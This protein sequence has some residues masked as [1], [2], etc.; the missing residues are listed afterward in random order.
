ML[1]PHTEILGLIA[2]GDWVD[3]FRYVAEPFR[4]TILPESDTRNLKAHII[5]KVMAAKDRFDVHFV[6]PGVDEYTPPDVGEW[7]DEETQLPV[8]GSSRE[9]GYF[10]RGNTGPRWMLG[11][12]MS[13]PFINAAHCEGKF[14]ISSIEGSNVY[15]STPSSSKMKQ[16]LAGRWLTFPSVD[17]CLVMFEGLLKVK[18]KKQG[19]HEEEEE[20]TAVREGQTL[21]IAAGQTFALEFA[22]GYVRAISFTNG[23]GIE[24]LIQTAGSPFAGFVL[25][26]EPVP[27]EEARLQEA[28]GQIGVQ[29]GDYL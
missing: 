24:E 11:G 3:F 21:T 28:A 27:W 25:P 18:L 7:L 26:D 29:L 5:P 8:P 1:G 19:L 2:P 10:L 23:R 12:V 22:S 15:H 6:R 13:R 17:H 20:W 14:A 4:G 9:R 16:P